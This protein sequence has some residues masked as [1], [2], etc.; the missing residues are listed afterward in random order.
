LIEQPEQV[1][2]LL[3]REITDAIAGD[4]T[5]L[6]LRAEDRRRAWHGQ[7]ALSP[8][9][10]VGTLSK[11]V[12]GVLDDATETLRGGRANAEA[13]TALGAGG[14][15][16]GLLGIP[17][18]AGRASGPAR[19]I[20]SASEFDRVQRG[21]VLV[22]SMTTTAWTPLF[23]RVAAIVTDNGG[24]GAHASIV[25]R[26]YGLPAVVG[27]GNATTRFHDGELLEVDGSSGTIRRIT[28]TTA[29]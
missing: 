27:T 26:E 2:F 22:A 18:S 12:A 15:A 11:M 21:D 10:M 7:H 8:P 5:L 28:A 23:G 29:S 14:G 1:F 4:R 17:A 9:L 24:V 13:A 3:H 25:A 16:D 6:A 20:R 19:I